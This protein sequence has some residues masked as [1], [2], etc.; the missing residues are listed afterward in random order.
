M[1]EHTQKLKRSK[2]SHVR[3][4][5]WHTE[6][7]FCEL[8]AWDLLIGIQNINGIGSLSGGNIVDC[9][10]LVTV[11]HHFHRLHHAYGQVETERNF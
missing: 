6:L 8:P 3:K 9:V 5:R 1:H 7:C 4:C 10:S 11:I 2:Y